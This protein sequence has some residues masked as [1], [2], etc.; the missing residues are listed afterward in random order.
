MRRIE[1]ALALL[2]VVPVS[3]F[4]Q[5]S[6]ANLVEYQL[7]N[8][9]YQEPD[10]LT[11]LYDQL[12]VSYRQGYVT[13][14]MKFETFQHPDQSKDYVNAS[15]RALRFGKNEFDITVGNFYEIFGRGILLRS[16]EIPGT[17]IED[18]GLR[19]RQGF[20][21][22]IDGVQLRYYGSF[23][24]LKAL[25][26]RPLR[27]E[28]P[29]TFDRELRRPDLI[30]GLESNWNLWRGWTFG[31]SYL[32]S[33]REVNGFSE[34]GDLSVSGNLPGDI[35]LYGELAH[36][37]GSGRHFFDLSETSSHGFYASAN[38]STR[39]LGASLEYKNYNDFLLG[40]NEPPPLVKEH[41]YVLLNRSTHVLDPRNETGWQAETF[42]RLKGDHM[43]TAN[44]AAADNNIFGTQY[45]FN[46]LFLELD[47]HVN[48]LS[49]FKFYY[50]RSRDE[51]VGQSDR[52]AFGLYAQTQWRSRW[53]ATMDLEYQDFVRDFDS[54]TIVRN[55]AA[56]L[57]L[58]RAPHL[59]GG[60]VLERST[61]PLETDDPRTEQIETAARHWLSLNAGWQIDNHHL[62]NLFYGRRRG[63]PACTAGICYEV[64]D[65]EGFELRWTTTF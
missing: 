1:L 44:Y 26:G 9:P 54:G 41:S 27:S 50:D 29:P 6:V 7:G 31:G 37:S 60:I 63:G 42:V 53:G 24:E 12:D 34:Y 20:Y 38:Y 14:I 47:F 64:L 25:R 56:I 57:S 21:R 46:E 30:E 49:S 23:V 62:V 16:F 52:N 35:Q 61:D 33:N 13:A 43:L 36:R 59:S 22:D 58:S 4:A 28:F 45:A 2:L 48:D 18:E 10:N 3:G 17:V 15:Q 5:F 65:F 39:A 51:V 8:L 40:F 19:I 55:Y 32:R 11:T